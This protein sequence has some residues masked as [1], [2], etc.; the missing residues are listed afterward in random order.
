M[1]VTDS[2][3]AVLESEH[4]ASPAAMV[5]A[6]THLMYGRIESMIVFRIGTPSQL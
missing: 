4:A 1:R 2:L 5:A 3:G 6:T